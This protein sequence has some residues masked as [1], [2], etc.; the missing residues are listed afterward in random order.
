MRRLLSFAAAMS[1]AAAV[2]LP[3]TAAAEETTPPPATEGS[4]ESGGP[5]SAYV[6][7]SIVYL[8]VVWKGYV[9]DTDRGY[10]DYIG[11]NGNAKLFTLPMQ[12]TGFVV[13]PDGYIAT[14]G[15]CVDPK[16][17]DIKAAFEQMAAQWAV[18]ND[19]DYTQFS[20]NTLLK[21]T[22]LFRVDS[23][24]NETIIKGKP[25]RVVK[26]AWSVSAGGVESGEVY[27]ARV[28]KFQP[29]NRGD[30]AILKIEKTDLPAVLVADNATLEPQTEIVSVGYP[31]SVDQ[32]T[33]VSLS[34]S[35]KDGTISSEK[36]IQD[37]LLKV[38]EISAAV[39]GGMSGGPTVDLEGNVVGM[40][41]FGIDASLE[42]QQFNFVRPTAQ[43]N[44]LMA[45]VGVENEQSETTQ[46][47]YEGLDALF[48]EDKEAAVAALETVVEEQPTNQMAADYLDQAQELPD[49]PAAT[50]SDGSSFPVV[51]V[52]VGA[53]VLLLLAAVGAFL[54]TRRKKATGSTAGPVAAE[55]PGAAQGGYQQ[56]ASSATPSFS[57][58]TAS[59]ATGSSV[60]GSPVTAQTGWAP[61]QSQP[62]TDMQPA[63]GYQPPSAPGHQPP[64][65][66]GHQPP[67]APGYQAP[68]AP[69]PQA[70]PAPAYQAPSDP[71]PRAG[72]PAQSSSPMGFGTGASQQPPERAGGGAS[73]AG[74]QRHAFCTS[75]GTRA[76]A[77]QKFCGSCGAAL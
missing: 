19:P 37:G 71:P 25:D 39:S 75:C 72:E 62:R 63:P 53:G 10:K 29:F 66:P 36:T 56:Q 48:A 31:A 57:G 49:P 16:G 50:E 26:A 60:T 55:W 32:V 35:F 13:N 59:T 51:P 14:A 24:V 68:S 52:A 4:A 17:A 69:G 58:M 44:E 54:Y 33:D 5:V 76:S 40:N 7:P 42:T 20:L 74:S 23:Y 8:S 47:Y 12:C 21:Y 67:S 27:T 45:D 73:P 30:G 70:P 22:S 28:V 1:M 43:I 61:Q 3:M 9:Y 64:S 77:D 65:A 38:Y 6:A 11:S 15:H 34:P 41:S 18:K 46:T 2:C